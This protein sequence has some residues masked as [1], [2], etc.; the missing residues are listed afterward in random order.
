M[1]DLAEPRGHA[2]CPRPLWLVH[3]AK[4]FNE[5]PVAYSLTK[6]LRKLIL[7]AESG[8]FRSWLNKNLNQIAI[9]KH[10]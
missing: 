4:F 1:D 9:T 6:R 3:V 2:P 5:T 7:A 10:S 8:R